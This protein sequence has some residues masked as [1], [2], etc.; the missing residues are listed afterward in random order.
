VEEV[1]CGVMTAVVPIDQ[2]ASDSFGLPLSLFVDAQAASEFICS[3]CDLVS[4]TPTEAPCGHLYCVVCLQA[5]AGHARCRAVHCAKTLTLPAHVRPSQ[6]LVRKRAQLRV[7]CPYFEHCKWTGVVTGLEAHVK[8][9]CAFAPVKCPSC[10]QWV[11]RNTLT[12]HLEKCIMVLEVCRD[13]GISFPRYQHDTH[14]Q[15]TCQGRHIKCP[16]G[17]GK[18]ILAKDIANHNCHSATRHCR[19]SNLGCDFAGEAKMLEDHYSKELNVHFALARRYSSSLKQVLDVAK[20]HKEPLLDNDVF[21]EFKATS[22]SWLVQKYEQVQ[23]ER[24]SRKPAGYGAAPQAKKNISWAELKD[25][26]GD[27]ALG[28]MGGLF[29]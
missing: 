9:Q 4:K 22:P 21:K 15:S 17:C 27:E 19:Y 24:A 7:N 18:D 12:E 29:D 6:F 8:D 14:M 20:D 5:D 26:S 13:C 2:I 11:V 28:D 16:V 1:K 25:D 23:S 3:K 10:S